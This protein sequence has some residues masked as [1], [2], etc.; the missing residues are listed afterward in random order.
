VHRL[1]KETSGV[2]ILALTEKAASELGVQFQNRQ[3]EKFYQGVVAGTLP[4]QGQWSHP[5]SDK[6]EGAQNPAGKASDRMPCE[7]LY[8]L[9][10]SSTYFSWI[11]FEIRTG[12]QHQIRKHC[13]LAG[14]ALIG[15]PRYGNPKYNAKIEKLYQFSRMALHCSR[16]VLAGGECLLA[17]TPTEFS[18]LFSND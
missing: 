13:A 15:D 9:L 5:L 3:T 1:D 12:R 17:P 2:Q 6:A 7:T 16:I 11:E 8:R 18:K 14:R 4:E 10:R